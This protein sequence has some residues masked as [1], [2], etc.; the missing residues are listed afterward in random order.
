MSMN[1][2]HG[3]FASATLSPKGQTLEVMHD[4][5]AQILKFTGCGTCGR[6]ARLR[7]DLLGDPP[8]DF[9]R[10]HIISFETGVAGG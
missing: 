3:G 5:V 10:D 4:I 2:K 1:A 9:S 6:I 7:V 8:A